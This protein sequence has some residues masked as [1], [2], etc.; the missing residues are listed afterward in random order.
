MRYADFK[1]LFG[2]LDVYHKGY[3]D[4]DSLL[5]VFKSNHVYCDDKG[6]KCLMKMFRKRV[7]EKISFNEFARLVSLS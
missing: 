2:L 4:S 3:L 6:L 1:E 5:T 7:D